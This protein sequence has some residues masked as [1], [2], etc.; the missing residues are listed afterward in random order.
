MKHFINL[1]FVV[2]II[3]FFESFIS[4]TTQKSEVTTIYSVLPDNDIDGKQ[5]FI[6]NGCAVCHTNKENSIG[7]HTK[8]IAEAYKGKKEQLI[9]FFKREAKPIVAPEDYAIMAANL[10]TTKK[11]SDK[12]RKAL[13]EYLL[14]H[15]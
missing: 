12:E 6:A 13:A 4:S 14:S 15:K 8:L 2:F 11:M 7:P 10:F 5:L 3:I 9:K 1:V